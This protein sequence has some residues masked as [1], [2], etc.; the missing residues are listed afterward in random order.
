MTKQV[1]A[2]DQTRQVIS[3]IDLGGVIDR[4]RFVHYWTKKSAELAETQYRNYLLLCKKYGQ[5][6]SLVP[7]HE[8]DEFWHNHV[9]CTR[10]YTQ[11]CEKIF[12]YYL[13][14]D[15]HHGSRGSIPH[16]EVVKNFTESTQ[17][18]YLKE[19]GEPLYRVESNWFV[20]L[21]IK[22]KWKLYRPY[23]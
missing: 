19:F 6:H 23:R 22:I 20:R 14:H 9:L 5:T 10:R 8:I 2:D 4:M 21:L 13:H 16:K 17:E 1:A 7:S 12:G 15:P 3:S 11:D 18:L